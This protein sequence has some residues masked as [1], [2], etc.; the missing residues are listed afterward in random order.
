MLAALKSSI[1]KLPFIR[2]LVADRDKLQQANI[3]LTA[4]LASR[5][6]ELTGLKRDMGF[7]PP[8]HFYSP[9]PALDEIRNAELRIFRDV[10]RDSAGPNLHEE[11]Q[12]TLLETLASYY[13][14]IPFPPQKVD[15]LRYY[16]DNDAY[17]YSDA[18]LLHCMI[19]FLKPARI[20]EIGSGFS[21][22]VT[23]DTNELFFAGSIETTFIEPYPQ[24]LTSLIKEKDKNSLRVTP[25]RV[26]DVDLSE[27]AALVADDILFVDSTHVSKVG[28]DV[29]HIVFDILPLLAKGVYV[30]FHDIFHPFEYP[31]EWIFAGRAWNEAYLLR[32]F[33]QYNDAFRVVLMNSFMQRYHEPFFCQR[34][35]LCLK[36]PG[37]SLWICKTGE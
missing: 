35:P 20:I 16:Y 31:K 32:A 21:S 18:I 29:N 5:N 33:L 6:S 8:G 17:S 28:S 10:G 24:L 1:K 19:R 12:L 36:N 13:D 14:D 22:C 26:Q 15:G 4:E 30:H 23:L 37:G 34:M 11:E 25:H 2:R 3:A 9:I 7:V 27:F